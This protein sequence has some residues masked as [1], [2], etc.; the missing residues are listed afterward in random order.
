MAE[1][2]GQEIATIARNYAPYLSGFMQQQGIAYMETS[3]EVILYYD[4]ERVP[5]IVFQEEGFTHWISGEFID[6]NRHFIRKKTMGAIN[7]YISQVNSGQQPDM[8]QDNDEL[9][10]RNS[11]NMMGAGTIESL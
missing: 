8:T 1:I 3:H 6:K 7:K 2:N 9:A 5:Y 11:T 10:R 4:V